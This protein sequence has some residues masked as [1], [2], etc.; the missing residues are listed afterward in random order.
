MRGTM[1]SCRSNRL[2]ILSRTEWIN[3]DA[4]EGGNLLLE[5]HYYHIR[6][7]KLPNF[8]GHVG[9]DIITLREAVPWGRLTA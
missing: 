5:S 1:G 8:S 4:E 9:D 3:I 6:I 2:F 7:T